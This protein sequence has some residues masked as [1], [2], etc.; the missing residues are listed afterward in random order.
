MNNKKIAS[1]LNKGIKF[2]TLKSGHTI[3]MDV[4]KL[5]SM[6]DLGGKKC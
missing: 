2:N 5:K 6:D 4:R 3:I 1:L